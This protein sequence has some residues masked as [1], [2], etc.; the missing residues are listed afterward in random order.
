MWGGGGDGGSAGKEAVVG[1]TTFDRQQ[2]L[3]ESRTLLVRENQTRPCHMF[4][5]VPGLAAAAVDLNPQADNVVPSTDAVAST[6]NA[7]PGLTA[8]AAAKL[9]CIS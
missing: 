3:S 2:A 7:P 5:H 1:V 4:T 8:A 9:T 6:G